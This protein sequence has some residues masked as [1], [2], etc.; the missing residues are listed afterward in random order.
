MD[1]IPISDADQFNPVNNTR[2]ETYFIVDGQLDA[3]VLRDALDRLI[4]QHWRKI[5][6]RIVNRPRDGK[7]EYHLPQTF[8]ADYELFRWTEEERD[9]SIDTVVSSSAIHPPSSEKTITLL[10]H[11][12]EVAACFKPA[13]WPL[14]RR[15][16]PADAPSFWVHL[17][18]FN[19]WTVVALNMSHVL[20]DQLGMGNIL[21]AWLGLVEGKVPPPMLGANE[22]ILARMKPYSEFSPSEVHRIGKHRIKSRLEN[23]LIILGLLPEMIFHRKE[24]GHTLFFPLPLIQSLRARYTKELTEKHGVAPNLTYGDVITGIMVK[25]SAHRG[26]LSTDNMLTWLDKFGRILYPKPR[27]LSIAQTVNRMSYFC[28]I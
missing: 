13:Q 6:A 1:V 2:T 8:D 25:V 20:G 19:D 27:M 17:S 16:E 9:V 21:R 18:L 28:P 10:P 14:C 4:R 24:V 5:G 26:A 11:S 3:A 22:D 12:T 15:D 7:L 23:F